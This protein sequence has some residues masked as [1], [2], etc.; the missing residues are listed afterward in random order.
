MPRVDRHPPGEF[1]WLELAT[2]DQ[3]AAKKFYPAL[4]GW[5]VNDYPMGPA[6]VYTIFRIDVV[7]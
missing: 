3:A 6:G 5:N 2:T 4:F 7:L 1:C